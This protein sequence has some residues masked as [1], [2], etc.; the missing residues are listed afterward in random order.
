MNPKVSLIILFYNQS[1]CNSDSIQGV[2]KQTLFREW[3]YYTGVVFEAVSKEL[4]AQDAF[5]GG[6]RYDNLSN[7]LGGKDMHAIGFVIGIK[8]KAANKN[9]LAQKKS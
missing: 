3:D 2:L 7:Q 8:R 6:G 9:F 5:L 4:G 1:K